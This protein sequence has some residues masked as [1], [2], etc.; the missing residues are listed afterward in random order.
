MMKKDQAIQYL[1]EML[2]KSLR[3][4]TTD[5]R[6]FLGQL[7]CLDARFI[8]ESWKKKVFDKLFQNIK[9]SPYLPNN[10]FA[11]DFDENYMLTHEQDC[12]L[13][14]DKTH[15]YRILSTQSA[16]SDEIEQE[17]NH[18]PNLSSRYVGLVVI[19]GRY[20]TRIEIEEFV[21]QL[22][23]S[24]RAEAGIPAKQKGQSMSKGDSSKEICDP[25]DSGCQEASEER[26][27]TNVLMAD[28]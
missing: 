5:T 13:I 8:A 15:E 6:M 12:N 20:I 27:E 24:R 11:C 18:S 17:T 28:E 25:L 14:L 4:T 21:S 10:P 26:K 19:P 9:P 3:I 16:I 1:T 22:S 7:K 2:G 23:T